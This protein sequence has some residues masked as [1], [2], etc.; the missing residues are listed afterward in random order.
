MRAR[1]LGIAAI[2]QQPALFAD[3]TVA[4]NIA[5]RM[6]GAAPGGRSAGASVCEAQ[7]FF[8]SASARQSLRRPACAS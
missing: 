8:S 2:Y 1:E 3:L 7:G 5:L 4:E 6:S